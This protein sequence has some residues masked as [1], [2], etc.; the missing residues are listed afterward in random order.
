M[1]Q[2]QKANPRC[3]KSFMPYWCGLDDT[4]D[5]GMDHQD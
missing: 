2:Q 5:M 1:I 3:F 4:F